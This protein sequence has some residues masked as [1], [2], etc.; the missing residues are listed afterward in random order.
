MALQKFIIECDSAKVGTFERELRQTA[1]KSN[2]VL[3]QL[4]PT[5]DGSKVMLPIIKPSA[6]VLP[7]TRRSSAGTPKSAAFRQAKSLQ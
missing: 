7:K 3:R 6:F 5:P 2:N 1:V 4:G